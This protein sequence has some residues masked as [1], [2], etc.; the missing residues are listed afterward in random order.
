MIPLRDV[1]PTRTTPYVTIGLVAINVLVFLY[2]FSLGPDVNQFV[3][4][5]GLV[6]AYFSW[7]NVFTSMFLHGGFLHVAGNMLYL[8]I[9][10][11]NVE[12]RMGHGR[13]LAF[14]LLCGDGGRPRTDA[15]GSRLR[16]ADGGRQRRGRGGHGGLLRPVSPLAHR[17]AAA[18]FIFIQIIE[19]PAIFFLGIWFVMQL[20][21][22]VG[23][24]AAATEG[25]PAGGWRSGHISPASRP[26]SWACS[27]SGARSGSASSGGT[28]SIDPS[29]LRTP[30]T[31]TVRLKP[32]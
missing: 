23:S 14:Y 3:L 25:H 29:Q 26:A 8:W 19:V 31:P 5:F 16:R 15:D 27:P 22:G 9:F 4:A 32:D 11:D 21:S 13:F 12:D 28:I 10:G 7:I 30:A 17:H 20:L 24:I 1:I 2:Q 6:P 18:L